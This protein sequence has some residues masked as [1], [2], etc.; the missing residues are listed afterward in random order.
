MADKINHAEQH[1]RVK[2][3]AATQG[4]SIATIWRIVRFG[5][6]PKP[7]KPFPRVTAW[8]ESDIIALMNHLGGV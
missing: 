2:T 8:R 3:V 4:V 7:I 5:N 1:Y 6:F